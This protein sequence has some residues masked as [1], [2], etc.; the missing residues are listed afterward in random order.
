MRV[1]PRLP[2]VSKNAGLRLGVQR[3]RRL[4]PL[5]A[6]PQQCNPL[7]PT[8][9]KTPRLS[10]SGSLCF[11]RGLARSLWTDVAAMVNPAQTSASHGTTN[12]IA[13]KDAIQALACQGA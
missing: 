10:I 3:K 9:I 1:A 5:W 8:R 2:Q 12:V 7:S 6:Y 13:L 11:C 4:K